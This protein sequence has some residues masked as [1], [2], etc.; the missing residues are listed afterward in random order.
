MRV[1]LPFLLIVPLCAEAD[2]PADVDIIILGEVHDN[3]DA[4]LG[5]A[6]QIEVLRPTAVVFEMLSPEHGVR[7]SQNSADIAAIWDEL[8]WPD[9]EIYQPIFEALGDAAIVG[10]AT[11]RPV[12]RQVFEEG[13]AAVFGEDAERFGLTV[14][15][16]EA[17]QQVREEMQFNAHC[18]AMPKE[19]MGA[20]VAVQRFRDA[21]FA[22][23][24]LEAL[25]L[26]GP[27]VAVI[28]G[29]GHA[30]TD[31]GIPAALKFAAPE[32]V[33]YSTG[34]VESDG[35]LPFDEVNIVPETTR[36]DPCAAFD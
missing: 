9:Y 16:P 36:P 13:A 29:N 11:P 33:V 10:A 34:F 12:I 25:D 22:K 2:P 3:A 6:Q 1:M 24:A 14:S 17:Q 19:M 18:Q 27:P 31:W 4:H 26:Y 5:Q 21:Q 32:L 30:R 35:T 8:P 7:A 28:T 15:L 20:M 23:S